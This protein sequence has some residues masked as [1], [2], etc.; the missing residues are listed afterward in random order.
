MIKNLQS[1]TRNKGERPQLDKY[2]LKT[3]ANTILTGE[4]F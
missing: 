2:F 4:K 3:T 1:G